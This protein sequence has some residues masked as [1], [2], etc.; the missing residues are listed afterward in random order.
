MESDINIYV[1]RELLISESMLLPTGFF[2]WGNR[3]V[4]KTGM[5]YEDSFLFV[6]FDY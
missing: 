5:K 6:A 1:P 4:T 2:D 3:S